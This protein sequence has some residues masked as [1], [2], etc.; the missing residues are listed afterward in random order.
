MDVIVNGEPKEIV[1]GTT[2]AQLLAGLRLQP[3]HVAV[4]RN[5][6]LV[7]RSEHAACILETGDR[8]EIVTLVGGG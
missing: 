3:R 2:V 6:N 8:L 1:P 7:P 5:R 4:E